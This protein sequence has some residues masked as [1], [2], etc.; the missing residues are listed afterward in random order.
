MHPRIILAIARKDAID[1]LLNKS[2][3][4]SLLVPILI[5]LLYLFIRLLNALIG[6]H[7]TDIL[8]YNP[9]Q[10]NV[11]QVVINAFS[12]SQVT[13]ANA[14]SEV[15]AAYGPNGSHKSSP[16]AVGLIIPANFESGL[17]ANNHPQVNLYINGDDV[18]THTAALMQAAIDNYARALANPQS[19]TTVATAVINPPSNTNFGVTLGKMFISISLLYSFIV[20]ITFVP[21]LL[22]EEKEKK[23]IRILMVTTASFGDVVVGKLL[24]VLIFQLLLSGLVLAIQSAFTGQ[25]SLVLLFALLGSC[26]SVALGLLF[27]SILRTS[28]AAEVVGGIVIFIFIVP[29]IIVGP[30]EHLLGNSPIVQVMR[31]VPTYYIADGIYSAIQNQGTWGNT[32]LDIG[33]I[34][35]CILV[36]LAISTWILRRQA[37]VAAA[38]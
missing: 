18:D 20:G 3:L 31:I 37:S 9:G 15:T 22:L 7:A 8:I 26:F 25:V 35:G 30:L 21:R 27:G 29:G 10:S 13:Q 6:S 12:G 5:S 33:V 1:I 38:I 36:L 28:T 24:V 4:F 17:R 32:L 16:Y 14:A 19:S 2:M 34:V 23:T 11:A